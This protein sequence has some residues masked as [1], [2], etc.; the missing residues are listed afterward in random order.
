MLSRSFDVPIADRTI[1]I[2]RDTNET[3][4]RLEIN[5]D[6]TGQADVKTGLAFFNHMLEQIAKHGLFDLT[7]YCDGDLEVDAHHTV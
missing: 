2:E 3:K 5:L 1:K 7:L 6:G 4:I